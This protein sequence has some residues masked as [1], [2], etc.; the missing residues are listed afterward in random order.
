M[1]GQLTAAWPR[2]LDAVCGGDAVRV[3][4][5]FIQLQDKRSQ[6]NGPGDLPVG[7]CETGRGC[8]KG[9]FKI[10]ARG[11]SCWHFSRI[12]ETLQMKNAQMHA[13]ASPAKVCGKHCEE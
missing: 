13:A 1:R 11:L 7:L 3:E 5:E 9:T 6:L 8:S 12:V 10:R 2:E 4:L